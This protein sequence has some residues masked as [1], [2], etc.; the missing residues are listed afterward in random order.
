MPSCV[1]TND[2]QTKFSSECVLGALPNSEL[3]VVFEADEAVKQVVLCQLASAP[4]N[5]N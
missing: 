3:D 2:F 4:G 5:I 1:L